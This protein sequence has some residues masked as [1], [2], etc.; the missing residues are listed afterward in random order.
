MA[1]RGGKQ[2]LGEPPLVRSVVVCCLCCWHPPLKGLNLVRARRDGFDAR[3]GS[4][5]GHALHTGVCEPCRPF[6][7]CGGRHLIEHAVACVQGFGHRPGSS[8]G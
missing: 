1:T 5:R 8:L 2:S 3:P 6:V 4:A 7:A